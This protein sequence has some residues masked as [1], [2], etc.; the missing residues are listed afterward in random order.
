MPPP[1]P[2]RAVWLPQ[3]R[4]DER[5]VDEEPDL[6]LVSATREEE[7]IPLAEL[8]RERRLPVRRFVE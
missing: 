3:L 8:A 7:E 2:A 6:C 1:H 5:L 4:A